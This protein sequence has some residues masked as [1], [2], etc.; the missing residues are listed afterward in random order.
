MSEARE[1]IITR[2]FEYSEAMKRGMYTHMQAYFRNLPVSRAQ[3]EVLGAIKHLQP[4]S[5]KEIAKQ[6][7]LTP[8]AVSQSV[9]SLDQLDYLVREADPADRR[10]QYLKLSQKG[11]RLL[12]DFEKSRRSMME[13][14]MKDLT[15]E[16]LTVWLKVQ[17]KVS[18][19][20][21]AAQAKT[22]AAHSK[23]KKEAK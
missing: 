4:V 22:Q 12:Q 16:E 17:I 20:Y 11:E 7:Y 5:S 13:Q 15:L 10:I 8:G 1:A 21:H 9:E 14:A 23:T 2:I 19:Q 6:L 3:F 18:E